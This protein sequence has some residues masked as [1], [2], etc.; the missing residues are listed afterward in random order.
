MFKSD[1]KFIVKEYTTFHYVNEKT[2]NERVIGIGIKNEE[3]GRVYPSPL[4]NFIRGKYRGKSKSLSSQRNA[5]YE[6]V[7]FMNYIRQQIV[8]ATTD[9]Q[10]L[11]ESGLFGLRRVHASHYIT[12]LS[13]RARGEELSSEYVYRVE[14]YII[15]FYEWLADNHIIDEQINFKDG[16]PFDD[17][18]LG[19]IYPGR[20]ESVS[21]KLVDFGENR[22]NLVQTFIKIAQDVAPEI[23][24]G[25]CF[26]VF[27]GLRTGEVVNLTK[28]AIEY[29]N[30]WNEK[31]LGESKFILKVRDRHTQLFEE[32]K[33]LQHE[34]VKRPRNQSL[35]TNSLLSSVYKEHKQ[36]LK[37]LENRNLIK[38]HDALFIA[39]RT[40]Q[41]MSGKAYKEQF[42]K[43]R[44]A[45]L[46]YISNNGQTEDYL[47]LTDKKWS[48]HIGRGIFTNFLLAIGA[49]V[50]EVAIARGDKNYLSIMDYVEE[51]NALK[52]T[53]DA[54]DNIRKAAE[55]KQAI[56]DKKT[57][58]KF[59]LW[60]QE[61]EH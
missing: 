24:L 13:L 55:D 60:E 30:Y 8:Q 34:G 39:K 48:T 22:Y 45:F 12:F 52:L 11:K 46:D 29:P 35:L 27:G 37:R 6:V 1:N 56:I 23:V 4:T 3:T 42:N 44:R 9:F 49:T 20:D 25:F 53:Q 54:I 26:Q 57:T 15:N 50:P 17:L 41:A 32:K 40:G 31:N 47:F 61:N 58:D 59:N 36:Y 43:V 18:E 33:N 14:K 38:N 19:T 51:K 21:E 5:A 7:K 28:D 2:F 16:S 10:E